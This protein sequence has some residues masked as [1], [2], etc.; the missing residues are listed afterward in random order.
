MKKKGRSA[1]LRRMVISDLVEYEP[2]VE[3]GDA[4]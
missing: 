3:M 2:E 1:T 4:L